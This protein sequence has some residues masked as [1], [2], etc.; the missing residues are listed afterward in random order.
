MNMV[1]IV[2]AVCALIV[3]VLNY[4]YRFATYVNRSRGIDRH[5]SDIPFVVQLLTILAGGV[6]H[7]AASRELPASWL[8]G[9]A[10]ADISLWGFLFAFVRGAI[11]SLIGVATF[12]VSVVALHLLQPGYDPTQQ[13]MSEL[14]LGPYGWAMFAAFAGLAIALFG[15]EDEL[16]DFGASV[17]YLGLLV[18]AAI[19]FLAAGVFPLGER[20][21]IHIGLIATAFVLGVLG[22]A[23][24]PLHAGRA[25]SAGPRAI[26]WPL[27][28]GVAASV[29]LGHSVF[30]M[31]IGQRLAAGCLLAWLVI[32][33][34]RLLLQRKQ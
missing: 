28:A 23:L 18:V 16:A 21:E 7:A 19:F 26:S 25:M 2:L 27:A 3:A 1:A 32:V 9:L 33:S 10:L 15:M 22:M 14:A 13:L 17:G 8:L 29:A 20:S 6:S 30:P 34:S 4:G 11:A 24:F 31:G 5:Y 12:V